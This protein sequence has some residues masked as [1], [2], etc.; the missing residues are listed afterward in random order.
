MS[1]VWIPGTVHDDRVTESGT[2]SQKAVIAD[3]DPLMRRL[4]LGIL[5][6]AGCQVITAVNGREAV[7]LA[8]RELPQLIVMDVV[9]SEMNGLD[10][11]RQLKQ[12]EAT[13]AI[14]VIMMTGKTDRKTRRESVAS[15]A[16][17]FLGKPFRPAQ[18][19]K[20]VRRVLQPRATKGSPNPDPP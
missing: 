5:K 11:L 4:C 12:A 20:A 13:K 18:L 16:A 8:T 15:G 1:A 10:A 19:L 6:L 14:P 3:D 7:E 17:A 9:M 2:M